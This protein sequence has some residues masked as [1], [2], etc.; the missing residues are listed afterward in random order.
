[1]AFIDSHYFNIAML[2]MIVCF[3]LIVGYLLLSTCL[4]IKNYIRRQLL[5]WLHVLLI[6][7]YKLFIQFF[8]ADA[9]IERQIDEEKRLVDKLFKLKTQ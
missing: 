3:T 8:T 2:F 5:G 7:N 4:I 1:M 6:L 9:D